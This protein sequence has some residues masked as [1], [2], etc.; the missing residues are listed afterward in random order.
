MVA[1]RQVPI[2]PILAPKL[3]LQVGGFGDR[4]PAPLW[5][6]ANL[7]IYRGTKAV[8]GHRTPKEKVSHGN[9]NVG[10]SILNNSSPE[11]VEQGR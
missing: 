2:Y 8:P 6:A 5:Y 9:L 7:Q 11:D 1:V 3:R 10:S 4:W